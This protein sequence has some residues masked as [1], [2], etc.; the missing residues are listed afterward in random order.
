MLFLH[1]TV[2]G[3][4]S[5]VTATI[6]SYSSVFAI[7]Y[8]SFIICQTF[9]WSSE[10]KL[11]Q[12]Y[13]QHVPVFTAFL[14]TQHIVQIEDN[15]EGIAHM[16]RHTQSPPKGIYCISHHGKTIYWSEDSED[17]YRESQYLRSAWKNNLFY[18]ST[19][20]K[21]HVIIVFPIIKSVICN[22]FH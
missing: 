17:L 9:C 16:A 10:S 20:F 3:V 22:F 1:A 19:L 15:L 18:I 12:S 11:S 7:T 2:S 21:R 6:W 4:I 13:L 5:R 14:H 8:K